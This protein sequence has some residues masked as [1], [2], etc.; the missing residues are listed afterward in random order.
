MSLVGTWDLESSENFDDFLKHL[1]LLVWWF[2]IGYWTKTKH[3]Y[4]MY[5][6]FLLLGVNFILRKAAG[7]IK[8]TMIIE[9]NGNVWTVK[10]HSSFKNQETTFTEGI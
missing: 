5:F 3:I 4:I 6:P 1:G 9:Q 7:S 2:W 10:V 8:P